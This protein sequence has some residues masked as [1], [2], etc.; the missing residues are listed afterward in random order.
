MFNVSRDTKDIYIGSSFNKSNNK[1]N[2]QPKKPIKPLNLLEDDVPK[3]IKLISKETSLKIQRRR[4]E[5][6]LTQKELALKINKNVSVIQEI[7]NGTA[8]Y[9]RNILNKL[10]RVLNI[11]L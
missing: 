11:K 8:K 6:K 5:L 4:Q 9:D 3:P 1:Q 7:E 10:E 2:S